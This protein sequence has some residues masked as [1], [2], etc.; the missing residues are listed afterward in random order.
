[1]KILR[2]CLFGVVLACAN[3]GGVIVGFV[4]YDLVKRANQMGIQVPVAAFSS[5]GAFVAWGWLI[6]HLPF[7]RLSLQGIDEFL[8]TYVASLLYFPVIF[9]PLHYGT[10][11]YF[12]SIGNILAVLLFQLPVN[13]LAVGGAALVSYSK[14]AR[15]HDIS[16]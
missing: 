7:K 6:C 16:A 3:I 4:V 14:T 9:V 13:A 8:L 15:S 1:M 10:Q 5:I 12:T 2:I 11:G